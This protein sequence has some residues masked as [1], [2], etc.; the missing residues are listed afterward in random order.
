MFGVQDC[1]LVT[2]CALESDDGGEV[3]IDKLYRIIE[4][5]RLGI[6]DLSRTTLDRPN[7]LPRFNMPFELGLFLGA[8]RY[9]VGNQKR[10][11][12][13]ILDR[14]RYRIQ[15]FCSDIAGQDVRAHHNDVA[16]ALVAM[17]TWL[18]TALPEPQHIPTAPALFQRYMAFG[19]QL[20]FMCHTRQ[21]TP[22][23]LT[24]LDFRDVVDAWIAEN[25]R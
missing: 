24:F 17:R 6:H 19:R 8:K 15:V 10:K 23:A 13:L 9:G 25:P 16:H 21:L 12:C 22:K 11:S 18:Q 1:G 14:D 20:P 4:S 2:R 3:R 5:C 7:R